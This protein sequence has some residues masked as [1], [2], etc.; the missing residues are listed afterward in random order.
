MDVNSG[1]L[2]DYLSRCH[3]RF[4]DRVLV[5]LKQIL[6]GNTIE[7]M[8]EFFRKKNQRKSIH[9]NTCA[10]INERE[11]GAVSTIL[12][13]AVRYITG[14]RKRQRTDEGDTFWYGKTPAV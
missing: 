8:E 7:S 14:R 9:E 5:A 12:S 4:A 3:F 13:T 1:V 11:K 10:G 2:E 6:P